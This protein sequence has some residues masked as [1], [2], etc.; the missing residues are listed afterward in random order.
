MAPPDIP[1]FLTCIV[2]E[3]VPEGMMKTI[4]A[5]S[6]YWKVKESPQLAST[7]LKALK[8]WPVAA[9]KFLISLEQ[10]KERVMAF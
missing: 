2:M 5:V 10:S 8:D 1:A 4:D 7:I 9:K 3:A 6:D